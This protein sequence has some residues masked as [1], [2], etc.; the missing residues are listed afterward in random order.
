MKLL[1]V[2]DSPT[3]AALIESFME[4]RFADKF[5]VEICT[6]SS[7]VPQLLAENHFDVVLTDVFMPEMDGY[8]VIQHLKSHHPDTAVI[9]MSSGYT[10][11]SAESSLQAAKFLGA[12]TS[13]NKNNL[14]SDLE[15]VFATF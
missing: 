15:R 7:E 3:I 5:E 4:Q 14:S 6:H 2:D 13:I 10:H 1:I 8:E 12:V 9:A 11:A